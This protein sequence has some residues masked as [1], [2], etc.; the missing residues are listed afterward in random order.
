MLKLKSC[1]VPTMGVYS[2]ISIIVER[3]EHQK[4]GSKTQ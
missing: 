1:E 3:L 4:L 2:F